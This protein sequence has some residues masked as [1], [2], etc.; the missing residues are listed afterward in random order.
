M[1]K[2]ALIIN[3]IQII[4]YNLYHVLIIFKYKLKIYIFYLIKNIH[5]I[6]HQ[7]IYLINLVIYIQV[8]VTNLDNQDIFQMIINK[9]NNNILNKIP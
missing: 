9:N 2:L 4:L 6:N 5:N 8:D 3:N 7:F 1:D